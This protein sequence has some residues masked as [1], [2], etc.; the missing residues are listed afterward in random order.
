MS[1]NKHLP[2][3]LIQKYSQPAITGVIKDN[4]IEQKNISFET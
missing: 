1:V 3:Y 2:E 4:M